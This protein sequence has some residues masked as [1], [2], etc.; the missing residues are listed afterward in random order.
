MVLISYVDGMSA[1]L[2]FQKPQNRNCQTDKS[3]NNSV[4]TSYYVSATRPSWSMLFGGTSA[5]NC[6]NR[7]E[8]TDTLCG[9]NAEFCTLKKVV[10]DSHCS[11]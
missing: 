6:E 3:F 2:G 11:L 1:Q 9:Q 10:H 5:V 4:R 7:T 8:H